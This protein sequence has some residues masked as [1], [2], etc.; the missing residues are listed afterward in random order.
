MTL[1]SVYLLPLVTEHGCSLKTVSLANKVP[2]TGPPR[3]CFP[4]SSEA[5]MALIKTQAEPV[6]PQH[7]WVSACHS[8][9][10]S[11]LFLMKDQHLP[12]RFWS[13][14]L[15]PFRIC[16]VLFILFCF[17]SLFPLHTFSGCWDLD[18]NTCNDVGSNG[19]IL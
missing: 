1:A 10:P 2:Q 12:L 11:P 17:G 4:S 14:C 19:E 18:F 3:G 5:C 8:L 13:M 15:A 6:S 9:C 7:P 16:F